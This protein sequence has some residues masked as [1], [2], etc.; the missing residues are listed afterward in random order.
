M[1]FV[2]INRNPIYFSTFFFFIFQIETTF[3]FQYFGDAF[4]SNNSFICCIK[5]SDNLK[6]LQKLLPND[7]LRK[8][9]YK[10]SASPECF[11]VLRNNFGKSL[12]AMCIVHWILGLGDRNLGNFLIDKTDGSLI[13]IDFNLAFGAATRNLHIPELIPFRLTSQFINTVKPLGCDGFLAKTMTHVLHTLSIENESI[14]AALE[15]FVREPTIQYSRNIFGSLHGPDS[16]DSSDK[17]WTPERNLK[18]IRDKLSGINPII[19][20]EHDIKM[21]YYS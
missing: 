13:G 6:K 2:E 7:T 20:I 17:A 10:L 1:I 16:L 5:I 21:C 3:F 9:L 4:Q 15:V 11:F 18:T 14:M 8:A 19:P 12:A